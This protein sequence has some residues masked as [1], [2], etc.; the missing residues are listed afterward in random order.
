MIT[1]SDITWSK[2]EQEIAKKAFEK[3]YEREIKALIQEVREQA[4]GIRE[5]DD[6]WCLHDFLSARRHEL[7]G[8]YDYRYPGLIFVFANLVREGWLQLDELEGLNADKL[9]KVSALTRMYG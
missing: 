3:A 6:M 9:T 7:D 5:V 1:V 4:S 2:T 8:K